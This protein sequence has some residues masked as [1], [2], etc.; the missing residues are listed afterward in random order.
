MQR[1]AV[2]ETAVNEYRQASADKDDIG[3]AWQLV[4]YPVPET[5]RPEFFS[6]HNLRPGIFSTD[7]G[8]A[9]AALPWRQHVSHVSQ[10]DA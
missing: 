5:E 1:A 10:A 2:P 4:V 7:T 3:P 8:H 6:D 9:A